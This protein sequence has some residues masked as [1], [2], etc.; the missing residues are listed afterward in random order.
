MGLSPW[1]GEAH[2]GWG[3]CPLDEDGHLRIPTGIT[4]CAHRDKQ[5]V[6]FGVAVQRHPAFIGKATLVLHS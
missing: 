5:F 6:A 3:F 4:E 1:A 2:P